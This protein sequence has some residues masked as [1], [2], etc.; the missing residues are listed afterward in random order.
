MKSS[1]AA[2][3]SGSQPYMKEQVMSASPHQLITLLY[4]G[5]IRFLH[6]VQDGFAEPDLQKR[7]EA[8]HNNTIRAQNI[9]TELNVSLD[10]ERGGEIA[11][12]LKDLYDFFHVELGRVNVTKDPST[13][14]STV[15]RITRMITELRETWMR[16]S[17]QEQQPSSAPFATVTR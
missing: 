9:L 6:G 5:L 13:D 14:V 16:I 8:I 17:T 7:H 12:Q 1:S 10:M 4:N 3:A 15:F 2:S 11:R